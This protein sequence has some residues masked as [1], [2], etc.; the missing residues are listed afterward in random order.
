MRTAIESI[1]QFVVFPGFLFCASVGLLA[2]W[3]ERKVSARL[4]WRVGPPWQQN[5]FDLI[6]L[7]GK[8]I[9]L[10]PSA[11]AAFILSPVMAAVSATFVATVLGKQ[12]YFGTGFSAD[13]IAV[14]YLLAVPALCLLLGASSSRNPL[15]SVGAAREMKMI[16]SYE[17]PLWLAV[18]AVAIKSGGHIRLAEIVGFQKANGSHIWSLSGALAFLVTLLV[19]QAK[20]GLAPFEVSEAEQEIMGGVLIEYSGLLLAFYKA[21]RAILLYAMPLFLITLFLGF[22]TGVLFL[23]LK[24][25]MIWT[26]FILI[27][28]TNPRV[29]IDQAMRFFW[30][31]VTVMALAAVVLAGLGY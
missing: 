26:L 3:V 1:L 19:A 27:K 18:I 16:L 2:G 7:A 6:K 5:F 31:P 28:N 4:Q 23:A 13:L 9:I 14:V 24:S 17:L 8:E 15:A 22:D 12:L 20:L 21:A 25:L 10:P 30:G 11:Q 29:R